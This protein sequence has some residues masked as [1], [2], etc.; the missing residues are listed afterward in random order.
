MTILEAIQKST[1][2]LVKKGVDSP[3]LQSELLLAHVLRTPRLKLYLDFSR[4]LNEQHTAEFREAI[5]RRGNRE[6]LQHIVGS[7]CFCG[8]EILVSP[9]VLIPRPETEMLA[10]EGWKYLNGLGRAATFLDFGTGSGCIAI[11]LCHFAKVSAGWAIDRSDEALTVA[12]ENAVKNSV[13]DR[14]TFLQSDRLAGLDPTLRFDLI[15]SNPP[16]IPGAEISV[17]QEEVRDFDPHLALDG[18]EDGLEFYRALAAESHNF[19]Q[20]SGRLLVE[21]GHEQEKSLPGIFAA[22]GWKVEAILNDYT[23]RPRLLKARRA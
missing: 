1:D 8:L 15:I 22:E 11:A 12:R 5:K 19:M 16:Y 14:I 21:F 20:P 4:E 17:L 3:R 13:A 10:E 18:G 23:A 9:Q 2:F 6:P 7:A